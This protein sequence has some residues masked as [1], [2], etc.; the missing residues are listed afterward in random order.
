MRNALTRGV[1]LFLAAFTVLNLLGDIRFARANAN[2]WWIDFWPVPLDLAWLFFGTLALVLSI[3][4]IAPA[5]AV[6][7][8]RRV[9]PRLQ[10][11]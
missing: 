2:L 11:R 9:P 7:F 8:R 6:P 1:S 10:I 3:H 4:A 5:R